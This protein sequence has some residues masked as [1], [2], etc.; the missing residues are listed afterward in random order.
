MRKCLILLVVSS[1]LL[2]CSKEEEQAYTDWPIIESYIMAGD[3][4]HL[5]LTHQVAFITD[6]IYADED[7]NALEITLTVDGASY[8]FEPNGEGEYTETFVPVEGEHEY[9]I[10]FEFNNDDVT[11][12]TSIPSKPTNFEIS[13]DYYEIERMDSTSMPDMESMPDP[14]D[15]TWDNDDGSYYLLIVE[16]MES[17][18][19]P[20]RDF[21]DVE[22]P[23]ARFRQRPNAASG[24]TLTP[25]EFQYYGTHRVILYHVN[26]DYA[27][28]Y[29]ESSNSSLNL[30]NP[31]SSIENG[32]GIFTGLS[33]DTLFVEVAEP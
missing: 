31:S 19:D 16:N 26:A 13:D 28:L 21:G 22:P 14:L 17:T 15:V 6:P 7:I 3:S 1:V 30:K 4:V 9:S 5:T 11:A 33:A 18:L 29:N 32:Y 20:I 2:S 24:T 27:E 23:G 25:M 8:L 10:A 12:Y